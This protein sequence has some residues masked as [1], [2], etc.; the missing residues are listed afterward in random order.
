MADW[1][2]SE[3]LADAWLFIPKGRVNGPLSPDDC[4]PALRETVLEGSFYEVV[5]DG[6]GATIARPPD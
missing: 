2:V 3:G 4:C 1:A 6:A 5:Y